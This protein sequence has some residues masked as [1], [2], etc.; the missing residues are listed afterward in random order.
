MGRKSKYWHMNNV[1]IT[2][3]VNINI[4]LV[5]YFFLSPAHCPL[6]SSAELLASSD[7]SFETHKSSTAQSKPHK[8]SKTSQCEVLP[9][10]HSAINSSSSHL[11][12]SQL[13]TH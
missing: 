11:H 7:V 13:P 10:S 5:K 2:K 1:W 9:F 8:V 3:R 12:A 6:S 4:N